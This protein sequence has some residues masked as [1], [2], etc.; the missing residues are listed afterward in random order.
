VPR[1]DRT[2][3]TAGP[4]GSAPLASLIDG[5]HGETIPAWDRG[6][7]YGDG[8][9]ET[10]L[11]RE[12][13]PCQWSRHRTRL[14][15]GCR[16]LGIPAPTTEILES[17]VRLLTAGLERAVLK[18]LVTRGIG[19]R[20]YRSLPAAEP[21]RILHVY[22]APEYPSAWPEH[23][24]AVRYCQTPASYNPALAGLKHLNRLDSVLARAEWD[25]PEIADGLMSG[26]DGEVVG[27]TMTNLFIWDGR[28]LLTPAVD[29][30]GIAGTVRALTLELARARAIP[31]V[32]ADI[33]PAVLA[34]AEG[35]FLTNSLVGVWPVRRLGER[36]LEPE[37]LPL[38][39]IAAVIREAQAPGGAAA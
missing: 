24:V 32:V 36:E 1:L 20:G 22:P 27:G 38:D 33:K 14:I 10:V 9:F 4:S 16:R 26:M 29:R 19:G 2:G 35:L 17:E 34:G 11:V 37:R 7:S 18:V 31:C 21:R 13:R 6:L 28:T 25:D 23:G 8:L 12:G 15:L 39:L 3:A 30:C 5:V